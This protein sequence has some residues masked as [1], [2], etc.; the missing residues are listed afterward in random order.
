MRFRP[1]LFAGRDNSLRL[2]HPCTTS[3]KSFQYKHLQ[4]TSPSDAVARR[5]NRTAE[6]AKGD[7][8]RF[9]NAVPEADVHHRPSIDHPF[10][11][12]Q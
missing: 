5:R 1:H 9:F 7:S 4:R 6:I 8:C 12:A 2:G 11:Y 3:R 10:S